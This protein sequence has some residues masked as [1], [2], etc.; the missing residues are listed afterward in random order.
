MKK[1][2]SIISIV[3]GGLILLSVIAPM[4]IG[5][6]LSSQSAGSV[7]IIGGA[8]GP[9]AVLLVGTLGAGSVI[10]EIVIG[11]LLIAV[12]IWGLIKCKKMK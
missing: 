10:V 11:V 7:G 6:I 3:V 12:G 2:L 4:I 9:T 8:D 1:V 5:A